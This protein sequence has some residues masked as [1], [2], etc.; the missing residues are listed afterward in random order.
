MNL[1]TPLPDSLLQ[2]EL[3]ELEVQR[4]LLQLTKALHFCHQDARLVHGNLCP[5]SIYINAKGDFKLSGLAFYVS[6]NKTQPA[7]APNKNDTA[8]NP[9]STVTPARD[10][11]L[12]PDGIVPFP[13]YDFGRTPYARASMDYLA[14]ECLLDHQVQAS[15]DIF[16][17]ACLIYALFNR[18]ASPLLRTRDRLQNYRANIDRMSAFSFDQCPMELRELLRRMARRNPLERPSLVEIQ[19]SSYF[20]N[21]LLSTINYLENLFE[22]TQVRFSIEGL[23]MNS[24][25]PM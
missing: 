9:F 3:D 21:L 16:A 18:G 12:L 15:S 4:G 5:E 11:N 19:Q 25:C 1:P 2:Y 20:E 6:L 14:P 22:Q 10:P 7:E 24:M 23:M 13:P 17:M 8:P